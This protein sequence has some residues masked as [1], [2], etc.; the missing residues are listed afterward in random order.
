MLLNGTKHLFTVPV[1]NTSS[2]VFINE[3][4]VSDMPYNWELKLIQTFRAAYKKAPFYKDVFLIIETLLA[5][6]KGQNI[7]FLSKESI[8]L[9]MNYLG[10]KTQ[11]VESSSLY[12]NREL[13]NQERVI[14]ICKKENAGIYINA[15]GGTLLYNK[16]DFEAE[17]IQLN[18]LR[19]NIKP[20]PQFDD[21]FTDR[22]SIIDLLMF[23][24]TDQ[25]KIMLDQFEL[26]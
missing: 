12:G 10:M 16:N 3:I 9:V 7:S 21:S 18:F 14:D 6:A 13:R 5:T 23:N 19:S 20:Y 24:S 26:I 8:C 15:I 22:L 25:I 1:K 11:I 2:N 4:Q 17:D